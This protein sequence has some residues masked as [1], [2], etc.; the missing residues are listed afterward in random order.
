MSSPIASRAA[1]VSS[2]SSGKRPSSPTAASSPL[3]KKVQKV[4]E[5]DADAFDED[6]V[7]DEEAFIES[8]IEAERA[9]S[10]SS[11]ASSSQGKSGSAGATL[12]TTK[13]AI[14][15]PAPAKSTP[16]TITQKPTTATS[17]SHGDPRIEEETLD[18]EWYH[19]LRVEIEKPYFKSL[20]SF[21]KDE[22]SA[23]RTTYPPASLIHSWSRMT[24]LS[25]VKVVVV[26]QDPY[27]GPG[28]ACGHSFSVPKGVP[29][30]GSLRN[31]YKELTTEYGSSF[32]APS[33]G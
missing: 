1:L 25:T 19:R 26:G 31:I 14:P 18:P 22:T 20:K 27:H 33:H 8:T 5:T 32:K 30:P 17:L 23:G 12:K 21:L 24:P 28:Q 7:F 9:R 11:Q 13:A 3:A 6:F 29:V 4:Q 15:T 10:S 2:G 16:S